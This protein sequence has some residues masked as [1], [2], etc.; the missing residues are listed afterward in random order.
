MTEGKK[1]NVYKIGETWLFYVK[2]PEGKA[3]LFRGLILEDYENVVKLRD[4]TTK[5]IVDIYKEN[6]IF[7]KKIYNGGLGK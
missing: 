4:R 2:M 6:L 5:T 7:A 3:Y 1:G